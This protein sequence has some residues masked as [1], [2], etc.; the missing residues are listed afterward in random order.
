MTIKSISLFEIDVWEKNSNWKQKNKFFSYVR[1][2]DENILLG[3]LG[4]KSERLLQQKIIVRTIYVWFDGSKYVRFDAWL[5]CLSLAYVCFF[6][7]FSLL[8]F[9]FL[10]LIL[11]SVYHIVRLSTS[12]HLSLSL[13]L[14]H[15]QRLFHFLSL[16]HT[17]S[18][19]PLPKTL[20]ER[21]L[22]TKGRLEKVCL[23]CRTK[24]E[25]IINNGFSSN[26]MFSYLRE[27]CAKKNENPNS[28]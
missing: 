23:F 16:I 8:S 4:E 19:N 3:T 7:S 2:Q 1:H 12:I 10:S 24:E 26:Y 6:L 14:L 25:G 28:I 15:T 27:E 20:V 9:P 21:I 18:W 22:P 5:C 11:W 17:W 13:S